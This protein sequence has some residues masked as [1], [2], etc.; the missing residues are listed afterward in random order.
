MIDIADEGAIYYYHYDGLGSVAALSNS[1]GDIVERYTYDV[2]GESTIYDCNNSVVSV[3]SVAN[4]YFFTGRRLDPETGLYYYRFRYYD[5]RMGRFLQTDPIGYYYS[6]NL[7][8]YCLNDPINWLDPFGLCPQRDLGPDYSSMTPRERFREYLKALREGGWHGL[9]IA[10]NEYSFGLSRR[11]RRRANRY[12]ERYGAAGR[13]SRRFG[14]VSRNAAIAAVALKASRWNV[15]MGK[16]PPH[17]GQGTHFQVNWWKS[18][19][20]GSGGRWSLP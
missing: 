10:A 12:V 5:P 13:W 18:G 11:L 14:R 9:Q 1:A 20:K 16:H 8:N 6:M 4:S 2:F 3:S 17:D 7:Y 15:K 19:V